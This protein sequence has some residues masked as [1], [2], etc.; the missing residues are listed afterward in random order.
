[1]QKKIVMVALTAVSAAAVAAT[2]A[3]R[4]PVQLAQRSSGA[5]PRPS[6]STPSQAP[7]YRP[8]AI[9][10]TANVSQALA[11]WSSLRQSDNYPFS[12]YSSFLVRHH[13]WPGETAMRKTAERAISL[14]GGTAP[15][16]VVNYF[17][18]QPA[19]TGTGHARHAFA[20]QALGR[21]AEAREAARQAWR[22]GVL[23]RP[24]E[25]RL[26]AQFAAALTQADHDA[27]MEALLDNNDTA[28][29]YRTLPR[30]SMARRAIYDARLAL[31]TRAPDAQGRLAALGSR[32]D[33]D[34]GILRDRANW[35][36][37]TGQSATARAILARSRN[38]VTRPADVEKWYETL[39]VMARGAANDRNW[40][41]A[42]QIASQLDDA[43]PAG[44]DVSTKSYGERD[45]YT[46]LAWLAGTAALHHLRRPADA[47]TM[48]ERYANAAK[49]PQTQ[50]KG[51]YWAGRAAQQA[52]QKPRADSLFARA[53]A[54]PDQYYG[55]LALERLGRQ[56]APPPVAAVSPSPSARAS[57]ASR[58]LVAAVRLLGQMGQHGDQSLFIRALSEQ[59][60]TNE[61]RQLAGEFGRQIGRPDLGV[62]VARNAR[63]DG[64][65]FY[66][67]SGFPEVSIPPAYSR[68]WTLNHAIMRQESSFDRAAVS[69]ASARGMM[70]LMPGTAREVAGK[71]G[72]SY[73]MSRLTSDP[74]YNIMLGSH[75]FSG[76]MDR[77]GNY[78]P[79]AVA[80]YNAGPGNVSKWIAANGD[81]RLPSVDVVRWV[82]E[83]P[84]FETRNYVQRVL[85]NAVVYDAMNPARARSPQQNRLSYYLGKSRQPG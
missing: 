61:E 16:E 39:L 22:S 47:A 24:D 26:L 30:T 51:M 21:T 12:S 3:P 59:I 25:D 40:S 38:L 65:S 63:T 54:H 53:A 2:V 10:P 42:Y 50:T 75:Y 77:Y 33:G 64:D 29:A 1:M 9:Q 67:R 44:T 82:E 4:P 76:L 34:A 27:R 15:S 78:A 56:V 48:F 20:L 32:A 14:E 72:M 58:D 68:Q 7:A 17:R 5:Y 83:I 11:Q 57:F 23:Q 79:L 31:Q 52:G 46:S 69:S 70:Q 41:T 73:N 55:Q 60:E 43:Y 80:A 74:Q 18:T 6:S 13:G 84:F 8:S 45:E 28:S 49:S 85:E 81:P 19:L 71:L 37:N 66:V 36:R 62:W 35:L